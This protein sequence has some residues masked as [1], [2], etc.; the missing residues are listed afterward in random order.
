MPFHWHGDT[1]DIPNGAIRTAYNEATSNQAFEF[2]NGKVVALQFHLEVN[3]KAVENLIKNSN[4]E[5]TQ[6][7]EEMLSKKD[8]FTV[9]KYQLYSVLNN[10]EKI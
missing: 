6:T 5:L 10:L 7:P 2:N 4:E 3:E 1:F 8:Y 9:I